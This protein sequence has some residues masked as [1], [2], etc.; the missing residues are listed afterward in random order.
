MRKLKLQ[1]QITLD[2]F[3]SGSNGETDWM[4][5][6]WD[7]AF[8]KY[9]YDL[10]ET[11]DTLLMGRKMSEEFLNHWEHIAANQPGSEWHSFAQ[12]MVDI[13]KI[14]FSESIASMK[15]KNVHVEN[16]NVTT[17]VHQLKRNMGKD[18]LV[19]GGATFASTL[20]KEKLV[21]ELYLFVNPVIIGTGKTIFAM[22]E[23]MQK[24]MFVSSK[25]FECGVIVLVYKTNTEV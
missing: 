15:G 17:I 10:A 1:V 13:P 23:R 5:P 11:S 22:T 9:E 6:V 4:P 18:I 21:D 16:G 8:R 7:E 14:V 12:K 20:I 25:Y 3:I 24:F 2:G 19:Y